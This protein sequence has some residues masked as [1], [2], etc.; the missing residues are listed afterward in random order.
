MSKAG[1]AAAGNAASGNGAAIPW[2]DR[3]PLGWARLETPGLTA[4]FWAAVLAFAAAFWITPLPPCIDYPQHLALG[5]ILRRMLDPS[6]PERSL[7][8]FTPLTY[9]GL[10]H[11]CVALLS[12]L[13]HPEVAGK[14]LL[15]AVP[16]LCA[17]AGLAL[18]R[19]GRRPRWYA[20]FLLPLSYGHIVGWG[21]VN[22]C[23]AAP[24]ALLVFCWWHRWHGGERRLLPRVIIGA[25]LVAY[26]HVLATACLCLSIALATLAQRTPRE[27]GWREWLRALVRAPLPVLPAGLFSVV[28][29]LYHRSAPHIF[30]E[31]A[32][33][34]M[35][36]AAWEKL[37]YLATFSV[38]NFY[39]PSD[40]VL[41]WLMLCCLAA[42]LLAPLVAA[43]RPGSGA[44]RELRVLAIAWFGLYLVVP[45]VLMSTHYI[46]ERLP[47]WWLA[48]T[49][50]SAPVLGSTLAA[51]LRRSVLAVGLVSGCNTI[52]HFAR[53]PDAQDASAII[54]EIPA[55]AR[56]VAVMHSSDAYPSI[57]RRVWVHLAAYHTVRRPGELAFSFTRYASLPVR[58]RTDQ[59]RPLYAG[60]LEWN[61]QLFDPNAAYTAYFNTVLV[62]TPDHAPHADPRELTFGYFAPQVRL[63]ARRGRY[64]LYDAA[65]IHAPS[66][67]LNP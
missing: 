11:V 14:L 64:F 22:Y 16:V 51:W 56:V 26:A 34:G 38:S 15:S 52:Y 61:P 20:C 10:F 45:R 46:F 37:W 28:V 7:Y 59:R 30:W 49:V 50:A 31:P 33:D 9:N 42:L 39:D 18:T 27:A 43:P 17:A 58:Y 6:S 19:L 36:N 29:F 4:A 24:L 23:L 54:D 41:F 5:A 55:G 3:V 47:I 62:K 2:Q 25:L 21:F 32:K 13:V 48:F 63:L 1:S 35:D 66:P 53:I 67:G 57:W 60:G 12:L 44:R 40:Q 8:E 65:A